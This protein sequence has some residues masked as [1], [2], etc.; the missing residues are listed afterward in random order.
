MHKLL[1]GIYDGLL[2]WE[3]IYKFWKG[4]PWCS[5]YRLHLANPLLIIDSETDKSLYTKQT[6]Q[7]LM[8]YDV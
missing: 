6:I 8:G 1:M 7:V 4:F 3:A 5:T 2:M